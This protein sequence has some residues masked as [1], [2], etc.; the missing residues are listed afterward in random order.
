MVVGG[1]RLVES[2][3]SEAVGR[4]ALGFT[5]LLS[6]QFHIINRTLQVIFYLFRNLN[7]KYYTDIS[8]NL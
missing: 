6:I 4:A 1:E 7:N 5:S 3:G 2:E 8:V